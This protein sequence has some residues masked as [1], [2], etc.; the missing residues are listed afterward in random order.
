M[1][2]SQSFVGNSSITYFSD[3]ISPECHTVRIVMYEKDV[4]F[5]II[6]CNPKNTPN[7]VKD[8][9]PYN[10]L[11]TM[12][13]RDLCL[14]FHDVIIQYA[15]ERFPHPP[16]LPVTPSERSQMRLALE[17]IHTDWLRPANEIMLTKSEKKRKVL[18]DAVKQSLI[19]SASLF[20]EKGFF[21]DREDISLLDCYLLPFLW[22]LP[23]LGIKIN[24]TPARSIVQ[25]MQR[26]FIH[27]SFLR[28]CSQ[29]ER[30]M[31]HV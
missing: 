6:H 15:E 22:R 14:Y 30:S 28:S 27:P 7:E 4:P 20:P 3:L 10:S 9:N 11:P 24:S 2:N 18:Q 25:Y 16:L 13:D 26:L 29:E 19:G 21:M 5:N 17:R 23:V 8:N 1:S 31:R 12:I